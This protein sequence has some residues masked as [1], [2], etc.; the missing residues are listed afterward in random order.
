MHGLPTYTEKHEQDLATEWSLTCSN[1][2][3]WTACQV[4]GLTPPINTEPLIICIIH[5]YVG[6]IPQTLAGS[7]LTL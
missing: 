6:R 4:M 1:H 7:W 5:N 3:T 2:L